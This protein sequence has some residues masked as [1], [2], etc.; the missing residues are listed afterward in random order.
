ML[1][2]KGSG[3][4]DDLAKFCPVSAATCP[5]A[6]FGLLLTGVTNLCSKF[7]DAGTKEFVFDCPKLEL[8]WTPLGRVSF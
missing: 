1:A 8:N 3:L 6:I 2:L 4:R 5:T 7:W